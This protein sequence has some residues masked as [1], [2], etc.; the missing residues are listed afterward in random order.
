VDIRKQ[1]SGV[2]ILVLGDIMLD[3]YW[4]GTVD[5]ISPEA[6]VPVVSL[7]EMTVVPG[8]AA[9]V[10]ANV[11][12]LGAEP[13]LVGCIGND[14]EGSM[15]TERLSASKISCDFLMRSKDRP[16]SVKTRVVAH[17]QHVVRVDKETRGPLGSDAE[18]QLVDRINDLVERADLVI[19]SDYAKGACSDN[20]ISKTIK[21]AR[22]KGLAV[23]VDPK[24]KDFSRYAGASILTPNRREAADASALDEH[25]PDVVNLAGPQLVRRLDLDAV[26]ITEGEKGMTLFQRESS[27]ISF[28]AEAHEIYDVTG[29]GDTVIAALGVAMAA[30]MPLIESVRLA[31][32]AASLV[33]E[34]VGTTAI[35][36]DRLLEKWTMRDNSSVG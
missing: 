25:L 18:Q 13:L 27:S 3:Q 10:A 30:G 11:A 35:T 21:A 12:G 7:N 32:T 9:N 29:A 36:L 20:V 26:V 31:N 19:I 15:L 4:W 23:L 14:N 5:R 17:S 1:F 33:V 24:G 2:K 28:G 6:P 34:Q 8:G 16:T 22:A